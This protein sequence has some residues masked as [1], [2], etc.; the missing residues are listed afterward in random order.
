MQL[1]DLKNNG[2]W[3]FGTYLK[4]RVVTNKNMLFVGTEP[5]FMDVTEA[6]SATRSAIPKMF[7]R[8]KGTEQ[9]F[10]HST[11][12]WNVCQK[13]EIAVWLSNESQTK[14]VLVNALY[15]ALV[16]KKFPTASFYM[17]IDELEPVVAKVKNQGI[18]G[19][20]ALI[21]PLFPTKTVR[22]AVK[23]KEGWRSQDASTMPEPS[24]SVVSEKESSAV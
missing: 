23:P 19:V 4:K 15:L 3:V 16:S 12:E 20:V 2:P 14:F 24:V 10:K 13:K 22:E 18:K 8:N 21:M 11:E 1:S 9:I 6:D 7:G 5:K 17:G